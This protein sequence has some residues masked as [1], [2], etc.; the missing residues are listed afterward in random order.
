M[1]DNILNKLDK[2]RTMVINKKKRSLFKDEV[3][4]YALE[5][6]SLNYLLCNPRCDGYTLFLISISS[7]G[8][9]L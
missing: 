7:F 2:K 9:R 3:L 4:K 6:E 5:E 8:I 1:I